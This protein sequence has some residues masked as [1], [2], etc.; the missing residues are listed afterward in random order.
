M[1]ELGVEPGSELTVRGAGERVTL[2]VRAGDAWGAPLLVSAA[3]LDRLA[4]TPAP[5]AVWLR[6][7]DDADP[8]AA[9]TA[10]QAIA[11]ADGATVAGGLDV[12]VQL[13]QVLSVVGAV[14][15]GL[16]GEAVLIALVGVSNTLSLSVLG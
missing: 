4:T 2:V 13:E 5:A 9:M 14:A 7:D 1:N 6:V 16:S 15:A 11:G 3:V 12:R 8:A 10:V